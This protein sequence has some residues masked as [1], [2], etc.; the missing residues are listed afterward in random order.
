MD[1]VFMAGKG[2]VAL[3]LLQLHHNPVVG[4][5]PGVFDGVLQ[6]RPVRLAAFQIR[7][8]GVVAFVVFVRGE[9]RR[10]YGKSSL[11]VLFFFLL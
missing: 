5:L 3:F 6:I 4:S 8:G 10:V 1:V 9:D 11:S 7:E 2:K